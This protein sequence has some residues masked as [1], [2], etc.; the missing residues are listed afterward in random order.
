MH[1]P[2]F[3][4]REMRVDLRRRDIRVAQKLLYGTQISAVHQEVGGK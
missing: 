4:V 3:F 2:E 1:L